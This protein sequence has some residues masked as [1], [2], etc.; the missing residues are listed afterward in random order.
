MILDN[1]HI[2]GL[3]LYSKETEY[4]KGDF[5]VYGNTIYICTAK[6]PT[7]IT[8]NTVSGVVPENSSD[9]FS[10]YLG[11]ELT[12]LE[13]YINYVNDPKGREKNDKLI[14]AH[15]LSRI[16][17]TYM[18]GFDEKGII[19]NY[20]Y[21]NS[22][23]SLSMS[24]ELS[25]FLSGK[26]VDSSNILSVILN[27][28]EI[29]NAV[30]KISR[31]LP[32]ISEVVFNSDSEFIYPEDSTYIILRQY[33]YTNE[34]END[35]IYRLQELIDPIGSV[36]RYRYG[37]GSYSSG[38]LSFDNVTSWLPSSIDKNWMGNIKRLEKLYLNKI[39]ELENIEKSLKNSFR[40]KEY[41]IPETTSVVEFQC[42]DKDKSNYLPVSRFDRESF[43]L[44]I[45][46]QENNVNTTVSIDLLDTYMKHDQV[47][48]YYLTDSSALIIVPGK[49]QKNKGEKVTI[50]V[51]SG[52]IVNIF[53]RDKYKDEKN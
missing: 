9:N 37:K 38:E 44:T 6:N 42:T 10:P 36:V 5:V 32:E 40:F 19:S 17:S 21:L 8:N 34:P 30:F 3:F 14:P 29:N 48:S 1:T 22:E 33:T 11:E 16:L 53:Y 39:K 47:S 15:L 45:V 52:N 20:V 12:S 43:I 13:E 4:E 23:D 41:S 31:N 25:D 46:T 27:T 26:G 35:S 7:N 24:S 28:K 50:Y 49:T 2:Q 51:T 18:M